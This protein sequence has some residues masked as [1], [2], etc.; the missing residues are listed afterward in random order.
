MRESE[1]K[2]T[3]RYY[4]TYQRSMLLGLIFVVCLGGTFM[5]QVFWPGNDGAGLLG[6]LAVSVV[7]AIALFAVHRVTLGGRSWRVRDPEVQTVLRDEWTRASRNR[8]FRVAFLVTFW[9]QV[10]LMFIMS[11]LPPEPS[12]PGVAWVT[13]TLGLATYYASY[14]Y[15]SRQQNDG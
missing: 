12:V 5:V 3:E 8:A 10:P 15:F 7:Y 4:L 9:A 14:L 1:R 13:M 2:E 6:A 11:Y